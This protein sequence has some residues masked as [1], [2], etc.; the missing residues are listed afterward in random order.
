MYIS[1]L[2]IRNYQCFEDT[3]VEFDPGVSVIIGENNSGK[4]ALLNA[5]RLIFEGGGARSLE[6]YD[7]YQGITTYDKPPRIS[8][9]AALSSTDGEDTPAEL[10]TVATWLT[11]VGEGKWEAKL[12]YHF[13]LPDSQHDEFDE[14]IGET[15]SRKQFWRAV[16]RVLPRYVARIDA[17]E[18]GVEE[19][20]YQRVEPRDLN[21][22]SVDFLDAIRDVERDMFSGRKPK[23]RTMLEAV[24]EEDDH[25]TDQLEED[26]KDLVE[27]LRE[28]I[29]LEALFELAEETGAEDGGAPDIDGVL[30]E[31]DVVRALRLVVEAESAGTLPVTY[32]G[33]GYNNLLYI[34][35]VLGTV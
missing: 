21:T 34:S 17:G 11:E 22:F 19:P 25:A 6:R 18:P 26:A 7:F 14:L 16:E 13:Y 15:P 3:R 1:S 27:D 20:G 24:L 4:S 8:I 30:R 9:T 12:T 28:R 31:R 23:L 29:D 35:L 2:W 5:L 10:G 33:L 32:N